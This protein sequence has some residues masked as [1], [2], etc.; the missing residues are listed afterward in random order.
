MNFVGCLRVVCMRCCAVVLEEDWF[1][2]VSLSCWSTCSCRRHGQRAGNLY[3]IFPYTHTL[4]SHLD[5][6]VSG[7][8]EELSGEA[9]L[10]FESAHFRPE[11][12]Q[13][14]KIKKRE[15]KKGGKSD[16]QALSDQINKQRDGRSVI[17]RRV[18]SSALVFSLSSHRQSYIGLVCISRFIDS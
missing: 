11:T 4:F 2:A 14:R 1:I 12:S 3:I 6:P 7:G 15:R 9:R 8:R 5:I 16:G 18:D 17:S 10:R 13:R